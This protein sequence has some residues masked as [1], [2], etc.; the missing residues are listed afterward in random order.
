[1]YNDNGVVTAGE[2]Q[3]VAE[4]VL[5]TPLSGLHLLTENLGDDGQDTP[6]SVGE[7]SYFY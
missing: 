5:V 7:P 6:E 1:M 3:M 2:N 4:I